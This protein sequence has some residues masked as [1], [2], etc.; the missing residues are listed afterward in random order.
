[1]LFTLEGNIGAGKSSALE[2][3]SKHLKIDKEFVVVYEPVDDWMNLKVKDSKKSL[4]ELYYEDNV[5]YG[6][7]FQMFALQTRFNHILETIRKHPGKIIICER[8]PLT[9]CEIFGKLLF[10]E[11]IISPTEYHV[12]LS[13]HQF[14]NKLI[15]PDIKGIIYLKTSTDVCTTRIIKRKRQGEGGINLDYLEKLNNQ[16][17]KWLNNEKEYPVLKIDGNKNI[18]ELPITEISQFINN[19]L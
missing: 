2:Y 18:D 3:I 17:E 5:K 11:G 16:H 13:W 12:Y 19:C 6:F 4:F 1:M 9:D 10:E 14:I 7:T 8:C 15:S